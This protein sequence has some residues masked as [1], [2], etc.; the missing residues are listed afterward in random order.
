MTHMSELL[1]P[2]QRGYPQP[3]KLVSISEVREVLDEIIAA[4]DTAGIDLP[5]AHQA[6][7]MVDRAL[8]HKR[9]V[10]Q[11]R[12]ERDSAPQK[13]AEGLVDGDLDIGKAAEQ[14]GR[15]EAVTGEVLRRAGAKTTRVALKR[16]MDHLRTN[17]DGDAV[18]EQCR[19]VVAE[20]VT[21]IKG[22]RP[23]LKDI[24]T[25]EDAVN[26]GPKQAAAWSSY[27]SQE[28][29]RFYAAHELVAVLRRLHIVEPLPVPEDADPR[30]LS[31]LATRAGRRYRNN[32][33]LPSKQRARKAG[34]PYLE[35]LDPA[36]DAAEPGGPFTADEIMEMQ[37][38][39]RTRDYNAQRRR[40]S[41][42]DASG[43]VFT[44]GT[45]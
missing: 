36:F 41:A 31:R 23:T 9:A 28:L 26:A 37:A 8:E 44:G 27:I 1:H 4:A 42:A 25:A 45:P 21:A 14:A 43:Q 30:E 39:Q 7:D 19:R 32:R 2:G 3:D 11:A 33:L 17:V 10:A 16:A 18:L 38:E 15:T 5:A 24:A 40:R 35:I 12:R 20:A 6:R 29:P 34:Q 22:L 13:L